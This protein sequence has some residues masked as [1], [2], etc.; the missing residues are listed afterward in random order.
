[1]NSKEL[2]QK[3]H[4]TKEFEMEKAEEFFRN[5]EYDALVMVG[6]NFNRFGYTSTDILKMFYERLPNEKKY[7]AVLDVYIGARD[8]KALAKYIKDIKKYRPFSYADEIKSL[9]DEK[10]DITIYRGCNETIDRVD[11]A[12]SWTTSENVATWFALRRTDW[13][14]CFVYC[15]KINIKSIIAFTNGRSEHEVL[16]YRNVRKIRLVRPVHFT[17]IAEHD[18]FLGKLKKSFD[19]PQSSLPC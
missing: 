8:G 15:G 5:K 13:Q 19:L 9:A 1:M 12:L 7:Q 4:E 14:N 3:M 18:D 11:K 2:E 10:G 17:N 6:G 16:Q